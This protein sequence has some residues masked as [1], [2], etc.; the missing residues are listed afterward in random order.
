MDGVSDKKDWNEIK[1]EQAKIIYELT[2][3]KRDEKRAVKQ[4]HYTD[5]ETMLIEILK[6]DDSLKLNN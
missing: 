2:K 4:K 1:N 5:C 6:E 3:K